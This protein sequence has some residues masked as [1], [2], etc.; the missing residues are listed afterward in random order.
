MVTIVLRI[1]LW[2]GHQISKVK[3]GTRPSIKVRVRRKWRTI[4][5]QTTRCGLVPNRGHSKLLRGGYCVINIKILPG[6]T[7]VDAKMT[8]NSETRRLPVNCR[9]HIQVGSRSISMTMSPSTWNAW[10]IMGVPCWGCK[11]PCR[12]KRYWK[13][14]C[15]GIP[16]TRT[17]KNTQR[18]LTYVR[19]SGS[20][21]I[22][23]NCP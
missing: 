6:G 5:Q 19:E 20:H 10:S 11:R 17:L 15:G 2:S 3:C 23:M 16:S 1:H 18:V 4:R 14:Y 21:H 9:T 22:G 7:Y 8:L 13:L 12:G